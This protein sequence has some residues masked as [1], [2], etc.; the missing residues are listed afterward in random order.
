MSSEKYLNNVLEISF[1]LKTKKLTYIY[2]SIYALKTQH[3][4]KKYDVNQLKTFETIVLKRKI[5][6]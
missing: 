1:A 3:I 5:K 2:V 4:S 6:S